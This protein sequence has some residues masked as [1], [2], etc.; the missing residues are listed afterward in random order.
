MSDFVSVLSDVLKYCDRDGESAAAVICEKFRTFSEL[1]A[2]DMTVIEELSNKKYAVMIRLIAAIASRRITD[3]FKFGRRHSEE[4]IEDFLRGYF[5]DSVN[6]TVIILPLDNKGNVIS[7]EVVVEGTV[8]FTQVLA[9]RLL[10]IM[11]KYR[12]DSAIIAHNHPGGKA[13][14]SIE[15]LETTHTVLRLLNSV[16]KTLV[17]H[18]IIAEDK[19]QKI[20]ASHLEKIID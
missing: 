3:K 19:I 13:S 17:C 20:D 15:D 8:N 7:A 9:R 16:G 1:A 12:S 11:M 14:A 4:E 10:E 5:L 18:Y 6:E 2:A